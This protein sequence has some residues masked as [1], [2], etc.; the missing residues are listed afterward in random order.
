MSWAVAAGTGAA[1]P[2]YVGYRW[3]RRHVRE[4]EMRRQL[5]DANAE[6]LRIPDHLSPAI[7]A[8]VHETHR[9]RLELET[10]VYRV[11]APLLSE[12]PWARRARCDDYDAALYEIRR[13]IW[14]WLRVLRRLGSE[15]RQLLGELGL[16]VAPVRRLL[17]GC[18]RTN[19]VWE[20]V[21]YAEAPDIDAV[22]AELHRTI[23]ELK[24]FERA[25]LGLSVDP[26]R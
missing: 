21:V 2:I 23:L 1:A 13:A 26:Y 11:R 17:F 10:P 20:Q 18:D 24:R 8:V 9:L 12:T 15:E 6:P 16:S 7:A 19:D 3:W 5:D 4:R 14:E 25:L 22:W